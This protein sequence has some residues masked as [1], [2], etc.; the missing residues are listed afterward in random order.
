MA[1]PRIGGLR[2][3]RLVPHRTT[4]HSRLLNMETLFVALLTGANFSV[5][6]QLIGADAAWRPEPIVVAVAIRR[7]GK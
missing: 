2:F 6:S 7:C 4:P 1:V 5:A 3:V